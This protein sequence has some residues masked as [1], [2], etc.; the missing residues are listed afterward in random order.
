M[1]QDQRQQGVPMTL[2]PQFSPSPRREG[3]RGQGS[4]RDAAAQGR[5]SKD[6]RAIKGFP[7]SMGFSWAM[8]A[9]LDLD[10]RV[11]S[12]WSG[13]GEAGAQQVGTRK[14]L[15]WLERGCGGRGGGTGLAPG[16]GSYLTPRKSTF[17]ASFPTLTNHT[18]L[19][20]G[21]A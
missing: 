2:G 6:S 9:W 12:R 15:A 16:D 18:G 20:E 3:H 4:A 19:S 17:Q 21:W 10:G 11:S 1:A 5:E 13:G 14:G 7:E 8:R